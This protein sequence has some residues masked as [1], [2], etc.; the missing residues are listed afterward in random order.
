MAIFDVDVSRDILAD[1]RL[2]AAG[3]I[4]VARV[5]D[6]RPGLF[7]EE[8]AYA[9]SVVRSRALEFAAG[10]M[11]AR[12]ALGRIGVPDCEIPRRGRLPVWPPSAVGSIAHTRSLAAAI[13]GPAADHDGIGIDVE[14]RTAV[15]PEVAE[16]VLTPAERAWL[17]APEWRSMVFSSK[18]AVYKAVYPLTGEFLGFGDVELDI[19]AGAGEF[20]AR[21]RRNLRSAVPVGAGRGY[22]AVYRGH[23]LVVFLIPRD[24]SCWR[25]DT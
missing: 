17:P 15:S 18:E 20:R 10:R 6:Y 22:W 8:A 12:R 19:D 16:R 7:P 5:R 2:A 14:N 21:C 11:V 3:E 24:G 9:S 4:A 25:A 23:W 1:S 13:V